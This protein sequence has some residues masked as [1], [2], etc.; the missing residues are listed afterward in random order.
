M[1][2]VEYNMP[3]LDSSGFSKTYI[4]VIINVV[5]YPDARFYKV[6]G[7]CTALL[8]PFSVTEK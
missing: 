5:R 4:N 1:Q 2:Y 6:L 7:R 8:S 3:D